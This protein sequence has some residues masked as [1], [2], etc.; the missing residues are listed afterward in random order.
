MREEWNTIAHSAWMKIVLVAI[1]LI[2]MLYAGVFLGS[3]WDPYGKT[4]DLPVAVVNHDKAT[5]YQGI[6]MDVGSDLVH[7]LKE[8]QAMD[9]QFVDD[10]TAEQGLE[11]GTYYMIITIPQDFSKNAT[12]VLDPQPKKMELQYTT[13]PGKNYIA[14]KMDD[15][16][17]NKIRERV[18]ES[19]TKAYV[20]TL[21]TK[22]NEMQQG[23][24]DAASGSKTLY[25]GSD[26]ARTGSETLYR[27]LELLSNRTL[28]FSD[29]TQTFEQGLMAYLQGTQTAKA[30]SQVLLNGMGSVK[31]RIP[32]LTTGVD[33]L[34]YGST[35]F[36]NGL[37]SYT[38]AVHILQTK[39]NNLVE[40][41][42][43]ITN[44]VDKLSN[45]LI[46]LQAGSQQVRN[47]MQQMSDT[48]GKTLDQQ[49]P[50]IQELKEKN[51]RV[52][53][54]LTTVNDQIA[55]IQKQ[56]GSLVGNQSGKVELLTSIKPNMNPTQQQMIDQWILDLKTID[57]TELMTSLNQLTQQSSSLQT[58]LMS[59]QQM[60]DGLSNGIQTITY[61]L[62]K[63]GTTADTY[64]M[65]Q[66]MNIVQNGLSQINANLQGQ[67][68]IVQG[69]KAYTQGTDALVRGITQI[70]QNS[71]SLIQ[72]FQQLQTGMTTFQ[73]EIPV[74]VDGIDQLY[75]GSHD[76][77]NGL[78]LI[79]KNN[80]RLSTS[81]LQ[82]S[83]GSI[84]LK[85]AS[86]Q[87]Y[88]G[89]YSLSNGIKDLSLGSDTL[90]SALQDGAA[91][92]NIQISDENDTMFAKPIELSKTEVNNVENN[93]HAMAPYMMSVGLY[94]ACMAFTLMYPL[95]KNNT[96]ATTGISMWMSKASVMYSVSTLMAIMMIVVLMLV[97]GMQPLFVWKTFVSGIVIAAAFMSMIVFL[98]VS[99]G[100]IGSFLVLIFMVLQLGGA[101]GTYPIET[102]STFFQAL[103]PF[104]PFTYSV[105][106]FRNTLAIGGNI[107]GD[108]FIFIVIFVVFTLLT[109]IFYHWRVSINDEQFCETYLAKLQ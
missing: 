50:A 39:G 69:I 102:S 25:D 108:L 82:I 12:T 18:S 94:V 76:V 2:P 68:G 107:S 99:C 71:S 61:Q 5:Q 44:G 32:D 72:G 10:R 90:T 29:G 1:I 40:N 97:N 47:G 77:Y 54:Q 46:Q 85:D 74:L 36:Q 78:E 81:F 27:S 9:F 31:Q 75:Q 91:K 38:E 17:M 13:N 56:L 4:S 15:S 83:D 84:Q 42:V 89:S 104:V 57:S 55:H 11:D 37:K 26:K 19:V 58:L 59:N 30:G 103:H 45:T 64:G 92:S 80:D 65:I 101:A 35:T 98:S 21:F 3:M 66:G 34:A 100:K 23:L 52:A 49:Q 95:L 70:D 41:N 60:I 14:T 63:T 28:T 106:A 67:Q 109:I 105:D 48:L 93:G 16:A 88:Q 22:L 43:T 51:S 79:T 96:K 7:N 33:Q 73:S 6:T 86:E 87:L 8:N 20:N 24:Q 62:D 53:K